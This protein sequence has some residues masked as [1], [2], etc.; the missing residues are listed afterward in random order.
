MNKVILSM[1]LKHKA[2][3]SIL[4][5]VLSVSA[6]LA[7]PQQASATTLDPFV[8]NP[9]VP[10]LTERAMA[11]ACPAGSTSDNQ[12]VGALYFSPSTLSSVPG[13]TLLL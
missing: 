13:S 10:N 4:F 1:G 6:C 12:T 3:L 9:G 7:L 8:D 5:L 2:F 11:N